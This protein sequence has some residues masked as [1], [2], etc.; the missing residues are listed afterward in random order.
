MFVPI[1]S[2][3]RCSKKEDLEKVNR[4]QPLFELHG[5][6]IAIFNYENVSFYRMRAITKERCVPISDWFIMP[7]KEFQVFVETLFK[8]NEM[9]IRV[10]R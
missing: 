1:P 6:K 4:L 7:R 10:P 2:I 8:L 9:C 3:I 5:F